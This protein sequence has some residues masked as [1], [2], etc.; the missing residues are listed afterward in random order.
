MDDTIKLHLMANGFADVEVDR[1]EYESA[2]AAGELDQMLDVYVS[3]IDTDVVV[4]EPD[5]TLV[6]LPE[7]NVWVP[8]AADQEVTDEMI[9]AAQRTMI[10]YGLAEQD[11]IKLED[12]T[13]DAID[14]ELAEIRDIGAQMPEMPSLDDVF[15]AVLTAALACG[16]GAAMRKPSES[17]G[18]HMADFDLFWRPL[19]TDE[20]GALDVDRVARA[21]ADYA[22]VMGEVAMV[23]DQITRGR[24][25]KPN[26]AAHHIVNRVNEIAAETFAD[27]LCERIANEDDEDISRDTVITIAEDWS[28]G[29]WDRF[30]ELREQRAAHAAVAGLNAASAS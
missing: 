14:T 26:T 21:L 5:G 2:K 9:V 19:V 27:D 24:F 8:V 6:A 4:E 12:V 17:S 1:A 16:G 3:D 10:R 18:G 28:A 13:D 29:A 15:R 23:Y 22:A 7:G 30:S 25:S 20:T 11:Q